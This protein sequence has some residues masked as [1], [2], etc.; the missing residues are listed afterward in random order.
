MDGF[1]K[2]TL[3]SATQER[4]LASELLHHR[5]MTIFFPLPL[6]LFVAHTTKL[7]TVVQH[8]KRVIE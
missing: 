7:Y 6:K 2:A 1:I 3:A 8:K 4:I 5:E